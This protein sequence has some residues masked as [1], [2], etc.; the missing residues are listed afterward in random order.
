MG[1]VQFVIFFFSDLPVYFVF[2]ITLNECRTSL[3]NGFTFKGV[4]IVNTSNDSVVVMVVWY[5]IEL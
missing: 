1:V 2:A 5:W 4:W 3:L